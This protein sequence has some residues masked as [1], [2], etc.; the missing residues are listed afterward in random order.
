[1]S[2]R[3][4]LDP[5]PGEH[6]G[7]WGA[8]PADETAAVTDLAAELPEQEWRELRSRA[9]AVPE[10]PELFFVDGSRRME[11]RLLLEDD[12]GIRAHGG[13]GTTAVGAVSVR[14]GE[15]ARF[16]EHVRIGRWLFTGA[17]QLHGPLEF[18][19][20]DGYLGALRFEHQP[21]AESDR[22]SILQALQNRMRLEEEHITAALV[23]AQPAGLV[24]CDGP[25]PQFVGA[26]QVVGY[27]KTTSAERLGPEQLA[28]VARLTA[29]GRTPVYLVGEGHRRHYEWVVR[30][31]DRAA[32]HHS[33]AGCVRLQ[34]RAAAG[35]AELPEFVRRVA[36]WS[37]AALPGFATHSI[38][39]RR[40]P[41]QLVP[42][43]ALE[44]ELKRRMGD[45]ALLARRIVREY[46]A[47]QHPG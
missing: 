10:W 29:G 46:F 6:D 43:M 39:D 38:Q 20:G 26:E 34:V 19:A 9:G 18:S 21:V 47:R 23:A 33:M 22:D 35:A 2:G 25:L 1:M 27:V 15:R 44:R 16:T 7:A 8:D 5:W 11:Q 12:G 37:C 32:W 17:G 36:D 45:P 14:P 31:A 41:Q 24:I 28:L 40:S 4:F 30:L 3:L 42:V 13:L